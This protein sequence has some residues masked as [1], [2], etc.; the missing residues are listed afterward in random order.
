MYYPFTKKR[1]CAQ[2][3]IQIVFQG[4]NLNVIF[5]GLIYLSLWPSFKLL[6]CPFRAVRFWDMFLSFVLMLLFQVRDDFLNVL[7]YCELWWRRNQRLFRDVFRLPK[8]RTFIDWNYSWRR[9]RRQHRLGSSKCFNCEI[10]LFPCQII[11]SFKNVCQWWWSGNCRPYP[12]FIPLES[13]RQKFS[14]SFNSH[15]YIS[16]IS[17]FIIIIIKRNTCGKKFEF[18]YHLIHLGD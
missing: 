7:S 4:L 18:R 8:R 6:V 13:F 2:H 11:A 3:W 12:S 5:N 10:C 14:W 16:D 17:N 1:G 9:D 15:H